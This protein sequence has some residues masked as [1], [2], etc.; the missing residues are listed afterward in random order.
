MSDIMWTKEYK[1]ERYRKMNE[2]ALKGKILAQVKNMYRM[3]K[4]TLWHITQ[5]I[6]RRQQMK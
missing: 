3:Q 4:Y 2:T 1:I 5:S 6:T